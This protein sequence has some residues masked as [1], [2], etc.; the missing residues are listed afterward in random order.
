MPKINPFHF[1]GELALGM[2]A[3]VTCA[4]IFGDP[5][6]KF[7]W[8]KD[9]KKLEDGH[10]I[11]VRKIDEFMISLVIEK[12]DADSNGNF[13]CRVSNAEGHDEKSALLSIK[14]LYLHVYLKVCYS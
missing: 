9:G 11:A 1:S 13:T 5:P 6:F 12:V 10:R 3:S 4:V 8:F 14:G 2:R 7:E